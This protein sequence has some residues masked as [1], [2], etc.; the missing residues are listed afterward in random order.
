MLTT[1]NDIPPNSTSPLPQDYFQGNADSIYS[2][3]AS[4]LMHEPQIACAPGPNAFANLAPAGT[5]F[6]VVTPH[7]QYPGLSTAVLASAA[8]SPL[9]AQVYQV[10]AAMR[11]GLTDGR[12]DT[13][14]DGVDAQGQAGASS[15]DADWLGSAE[16]LPMSYT[17]G[18]V[19]ERN[20]TPRRKGPPQRESSGVRWGNPPLQSPGGGCPG[21]MDGLSIWAKLFLAAGA[22]VILLAAIQD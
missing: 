18:M 12:S 14:I 5:L 7:S 4:G 22:G 9:A 19:E 1:M 13:L 2:L 6:P 17:A 21:G 3:F 10:Q 8:V 16:V 15:T 20:P 11:Q